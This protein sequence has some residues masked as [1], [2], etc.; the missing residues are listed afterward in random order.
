M[1]MPIN[2]EDLIRRKVVKNTRVEYNAYG[3]PNGTD[4][5][6]TADIK[7]VIGGQ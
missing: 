6:Q 1:D 4:V 2:I 7:A 5:R 3:V